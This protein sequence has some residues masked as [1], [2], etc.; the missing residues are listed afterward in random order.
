MNCCTH[1]LIYNKLINSPR[2][3]T[4][5]PPLCLGIRL[6]RCP[7]HPIHLVSC[8]QRFQSFFS[9]H[10]FNQF[11][12]CSV[13]PSQS[14]CIVLILSVEVLGSSSAV[15]FSLE[16]GKKVQFVPVFYDSS[17]YLSMCGT[18]SRYLFFK[19]I[20]LF[21]PCLWCKLLFNL[22]LWCSSQ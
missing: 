15:V 7:P 22:F 18:K 5:F 9:F 11:C 19:F 13:T 10:L 3:L 21:L 16:R 14:V 1:I 20:F 4:T 12:Y 2:I 8:Q 17:M 6:C